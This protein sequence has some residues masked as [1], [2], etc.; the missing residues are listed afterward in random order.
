MNNVRD[1][2]ANETNA[3]EKEKLK[4]RE[5]QIL[6]ARYQKVLGG[7]GYERYADTLEMPTYTEE[8]TDPAKQWRVDIAVARETLASD[9]YNQ[10]QN[11]AAEAADN[12]AN[13]QM[14]YRINAENNQAEQAKPTLTA[15][16][17]KKA[18]EDGI[19]TE[20]TV[21]AFNY[22]FGSNYTVDN[23]PKIAGGPMSDEDVKWWVDDLN[24]QVEEKYPGKTAINKTGANTYGK[25]DIDAD[26]IIRKVLESDSLTP[27]QQEYLL[28]DK[29]GITDDQ[30]NTAM[31]D[32]HYR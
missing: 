31:K 25:G 7:L 4:E 12:E 20:A 19:I 2:I 26:W 6:A 21:A 18:I 1:Q 8:L 11:R 10:E 27:E 16:Q 5:Q 13:R 9:N 28:Y 22:H 14:Q 30:V 15:E 3:A 23:I 29:F 17:A 24:K 32:P